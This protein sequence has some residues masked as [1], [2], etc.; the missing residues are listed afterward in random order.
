MKAKNVE[1][2]FLREIRCLCLFH[3][4]LSDSVFTLQGGRAVFS[5]NAISI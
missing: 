2:S 1:S 3:V 5:I 4:Q